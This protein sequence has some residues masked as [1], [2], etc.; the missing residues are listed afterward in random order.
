MQA[1]FVAIAGRRE[2][3]EVLLEAH[4]ETNGDLPVMG[5]GSRSRPGR[6]FVGAV[7][8][9]MLAKSDMPVLMLHT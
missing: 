2:R 4:C 6:R 9:Y 5:A 8:G 1:I 7:A 3:A